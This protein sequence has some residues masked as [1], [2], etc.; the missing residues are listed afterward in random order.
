MCVRKLTLLLM[1]PIVAF[2]TG[3]SSN[4]KIVLAYKLININITLDGKLTEPIWQREPI[5]EFVQKDPNEGTPS[6][7]QTNVWVAFDNDYIYVAAK[8]YDSKP[9]LID[10]S[11]ARRDN[12]FSSDWFAF[13]VDPYNDKKTGYFFGVNAGGTMLDG[14]LFN[15]SWDDWSWDGIWE[16]KTTIESDGWTVEMRIPFSQMRFNHTDA[17]TWGVNFYRELKRNNEKSYYVMVPKAESGFVSRF[18]SLEGLNGIQPKQRFEVMPYMVQKAQ[19]LV[20]DKEDPFYK[21][22]Q[23]KTS[24]GA[25]FKIGIG[26]NFNIDATINPDFGQVEVDPAVINLSAFESYFNE[27]RPFFIEGMENFYFGI[28][29]ANNN[30]GFNFGWPE[31]FYSRRIGRSPRG[32]ISDAEYVKYPSE[33][34]IL[35]AAKITGKFNESTTLGAISAITERTYAT[36]WNNGIRTNEE[37]EPLTFYNVLRSKKDFNEGRQSLGFMFTSVNRDFVTNTPSNNLAK[38]AYAFGLD[39]WTFLD[40]DKEYVLTGAFAGTYVNGSKEYLK[41]LQM[42]PYRYFQRPDGSFETFDPDRTSLSGYYGRIMLNKQKGNFYINSAL[43]FVSPGFEQNDLGFQ[44]M[45]DRINLHTVL[46]YRWFE[47]D[48]IFRSKQVY[49]SYSRSMNFNGETISNF[50][51]YRLGG[52]FNNYYE[53]SMGGNYNFE[54]YNP[55]L[56]RGG[57]LGINPSSYFFWIFGS[58]DRREKLSVNSE[59]DFSRSAVGGKYNEINLSITWKPNT[60]LTFSI[61]P[62]FEVSKSMQQWVKNI[63][64]PAAVNTYNTRYVFATIK[65]HT[66]SANIRLNWTFTPALSLQLFMQPFFAVGNYSDF[67]ELAQPRSLNYNYYGQSG[68]TINYDNNKRKYTVDPDGTGPAN[69]FTFSNPD[70]NYK[71]LRGTAVL[72]WETMPGSVLYFVWSHNQT[73]FD[74]AGEFNL[75]RD[76]KHLWS[77]EGD[78][79]FMIKFSYWLDI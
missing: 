52:T 48:G 53:L 19:Y 36:L 28:G 42:Q 1:L 76:F 20:H 64:D 17:M 31:L 55:A 10:A 30:W 39:G 60:Q 54:T 43:G 16:T 41:N 26:S 73:N 3:K 2:A 46:G 9:E 14:V 68:S 38:N 78:D 24:V 11:I 58:S 57:P 79:V 62:S 77:S 12:Y 6:S 25:D 29:G 40:E 44:W 67:K 74:N 37:I 27:K 49:A 21:S 70:F 63:D 51:W 34:R 5:K 45:A 65:Q 69:S 22:N 50:L 23:Y 35:G 61:G 72:R 8:L 56:T 32:N 59:L 15:D 33:T 71:S 75:S 13:Y 66:L 4:E 47:P 7:E 18:A